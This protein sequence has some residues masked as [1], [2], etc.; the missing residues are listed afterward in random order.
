MMAA[1]LGHTVMPRPESKGKANPK[2]LDSFG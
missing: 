1:V 2:A